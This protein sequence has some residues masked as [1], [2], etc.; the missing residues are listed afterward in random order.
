MSQNTHNGPVTN[1]LGTSDEIIW[2]DYNKR[3]VVLFKRDWFK[4]DGK[5]TELKDGLSFLTNLDM[6]ART[7]RRLEIRTALLIDKDC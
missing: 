2:L 1:F 5:R 7:C 6:W 3:S 4:L